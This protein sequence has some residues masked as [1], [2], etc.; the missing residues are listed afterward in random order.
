MGDPDG[1]VVVST[2]IA[3][4]VAEATLEV[5]R[6][7]LEIVQDMQSGTRR[8]GAMAPRPRF[9]HVKALKNRIAAHSPS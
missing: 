9:A 7:E 2:G 3:E 1:L 5:M 4:V 6:I 8:V